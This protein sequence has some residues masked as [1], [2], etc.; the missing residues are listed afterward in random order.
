M[1]VA[2][3]RQVSG[4]YSLSTAAFCPRESTD[5]S[6]QNYPGLRSSASPTTTV[7]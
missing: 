4:M 2:A 7:R 5:D 3:R 6:M 1:E